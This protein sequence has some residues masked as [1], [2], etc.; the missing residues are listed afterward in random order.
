MKL[1]SGVFD[2]RRGWVRILGWG[3]SWRPSAEGDV[4]SERYRY[5]KAVSIGPVRFRWLNRA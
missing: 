1:V 2:V 4:F 3:V 5:A